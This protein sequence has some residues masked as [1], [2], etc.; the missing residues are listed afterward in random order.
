MREVAD[1]LRAVVGEANG[2]ALALH[3]TPAP[4]M[5]QEP[6]LLGEDNEDK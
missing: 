3:P 4:T 5:L 6:Q 2:F 1:V